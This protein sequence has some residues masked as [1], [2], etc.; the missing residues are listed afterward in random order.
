MTL[1]DLPV[2]TGPI[3]GGT[4][5]YRE[6]P[7]CEAAKVPFRRVNLVGGEHLDDPYGTPRPYTD[8]GAVIDLT[9]DRAP[10]PGHRGNPAYLP[11]DLVRAPTSARAR[12]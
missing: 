11:L 8:P 4:K 2:A 10:R 7:G 9:R 3:T 5:A 12:S 1:T 6:A